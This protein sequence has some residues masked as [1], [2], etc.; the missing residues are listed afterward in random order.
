[1][2]L[3]A[4]IV[5]LFFVVLVGCGIFV[6]VYMYLNGAFSEKIRRGRKPHLS[7][8]SLGQMG[9]IPT[10]T[11][12]ARLYPA[13]KRARMNAHTRLFLLYSLGILLSLTVL[14]VLVLGATQ[15]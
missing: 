15:F 6:N 4:T 1:M 10:T 5:A 11:A 8:V 7:A 13:G 12:A 3:I 9:T 14:V 2:T